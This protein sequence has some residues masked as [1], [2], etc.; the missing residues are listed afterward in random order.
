MAH[1]LLAP[2]I[3]PTSPWPRDW[4][5]ELSYRRHS[6]RLAALLEP[7]AARGTT[8]G[9][10]WWLV[11][12]PRRHRDHPVSPR[13]GFSSSA[14][15]GPGSWQPLTESIRCAAG[16][17]CSASAGDGLRLRS[18]LPGGPRSSSTRLAPT[19]SAWL[20]FIL[21][22]DDAR[23][24]TA[25]LSEVLA[26]AQSRCRFMSAAIEVS[27]RDL[28]TAPGARDQDRQARQHRPDVSANAS[29]SQAQLR[30]AL[31]QARAS[32]PPRP[33][34]RDLAELWPRR[35]SAPGGELVY[36]MPEAGAPRPEVPTGALLGDGGDRGTPCAP[37][38][39]PA[40]P[41]G[42]PSCWSP[43]SGPAPPRSQ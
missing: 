32:A 36:S 7:G 5:E 35:S 33:L 11:Q 37:T 40:C 31:A 1:Y 42:V 24:F 22:D 15:P 12:C 16:A 38:P 6:G 17:R 41:G 10:N 3:V 34:S 19:R 18:P 21:S 39:P 2:G 14:R 13:S 8:F 29:R 25:T 28:A 43:P 9:G 20:P 26:R 30:K 27:Q 4:A 23:A